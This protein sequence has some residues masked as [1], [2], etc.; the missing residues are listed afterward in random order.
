MPVLPEVETVLRELE[1]DLRD[2]TVVGAEVHWGRTV[3]EPDAE[4]KNAERRSLK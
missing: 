4:I 3:A 1:P 2:R